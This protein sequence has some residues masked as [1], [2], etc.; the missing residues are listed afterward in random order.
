M[1]FFGKSQQILFIIEIFLIRVNMNQNVNIEEI[2]IF[3]EKP[4]EL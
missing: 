4:D 2:F 3:D 1:G